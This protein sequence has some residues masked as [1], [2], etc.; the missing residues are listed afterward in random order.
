MMN[1][2]L[3]RDFADFDKQFEMLSIATE[4]TRCHLEVLPRD[5]RARKSLTA[6]KFDLDTATH[7]LLS[8]EM[9]TRDGSSLR[10]EFTNVQVN[11]KIDHSVFDFDFTGYDVV[12]AKP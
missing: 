2:P 7:Y 8:F 4:G 1:F 11:T 6:L 5:P 9:I 3:A 10:N 12:D